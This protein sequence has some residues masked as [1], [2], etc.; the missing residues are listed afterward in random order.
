MYC[1]ELFVDSNANQRLPE[2]MEHEVLVSNSWA[3]RLL[4]VMVGIR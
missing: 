3:E 1:D 2:L 4:G